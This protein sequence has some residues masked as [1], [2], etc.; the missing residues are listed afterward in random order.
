MWITTA[1]NYQID[2]NCTLL[3]CF[4]ISKAIVHFQNNIFLPQQGEGPEVGFHPFCGIWCK[5][6]INKPRTP[7]SY[8][9]CFLRVLCYWFSSNQAAFLLEGAIGTTDVVLLGTLERGMDI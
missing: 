2:S 9:Y 7:V 6:T 5:Q 8:E 1:P 4:C 3:A